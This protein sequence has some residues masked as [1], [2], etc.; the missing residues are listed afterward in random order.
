MVD[1]FSGLIATV[2]LDV[3]EVSF[4]K[5]VDVGSILVAE[6]VSFVVAEKLLSFGAVDAA[7]SVVL[8]YEEKELVTE[9][10]E[11]PIMVARS[12]ITLEVPFG[13][14]PY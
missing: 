12:I 10:T 11:T 5:P 14:F 7:V 13:Q 2:V 4:S 8:V 1:S 9:L 3:D 6:A